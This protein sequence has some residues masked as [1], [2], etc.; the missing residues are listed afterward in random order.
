LPQI[1]TSEVSPMY[2]I[3]SSARYQV[4]KWYAAAEGRPP[5]C[6]SLGFLRLSEFL[7]RVRVDQGQHKAGD[8]GY[9][10]YPN[11]P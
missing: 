9:A 6:E 11:R 2:L 4:S 8:E 5:P 1:S 7:A 10:S 3:F